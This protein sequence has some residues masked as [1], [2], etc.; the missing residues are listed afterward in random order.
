VV[1]LISPQ[2]L[3]R[4]TIGPSFLFIFDVSRDSVAAGLAQSAAASVSAS[5]VCLPDDALISLV[6][7][8]RDLCVVDLR[9]NRQLIVADGESI[10][11][12]VR[13]VRLRDCRSVLAA[14]L[15]RLSHLSA[16]SAPG[17]CLGAALEASARLLADCG[18]IAL[19]FVCGAPSHGPGCLPRRSA[20]DL[21]HEPSL[22]KPP[23]SAA[24]HF[25]RELALRLSSLCVSL[26]LF[27]AGL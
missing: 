16:S 5:L 19:G 12:G 14:H 20:G 4:P 21:S 23:A 9:R 25:Y 3:Y 8:D 2:K 1:D 15:S 24:T 22:F 18:G 7:V 6:T 27:T 10:D 17:H 26:S 13:P 11:L